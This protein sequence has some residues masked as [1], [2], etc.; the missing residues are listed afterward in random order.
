[1]KILKNTWLIFLYFL[2]SCTSAYKQAGIDFVKDYSNEAS[3]DGLKLASVQG[4]FSRQCPVS[5]YYICDYKAD[6]NYAR[7]ILVKNVENFIEKINNDETIRNYLIHY[8]ISYNDFDFYIIF[9]GNENIDLYPFKPYLAGVYVTHQGAFS[10]EGLVEYNGRDPT[11]GKLEDI[12]LESYT[13]AKGIVEH[14][15]N[16]SALEGH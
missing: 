4:S 3:L 13:R 7:N 6:V 11:T 8:P 10:K 5:I 12:H 16:V 14:Q 9:L 15:R 2:I 1:M